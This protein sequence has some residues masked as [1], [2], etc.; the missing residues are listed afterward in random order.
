MNPDEKSKLIAKLHIEL[1]SIKKKIKELEELTRPISPSDAIG[2][3]SRMDAINN[4]SINESALRTAKTKLRNIE[5]TLEKSESEDFGKCRQCGT[6]IPLGRLMVM[7][8][9]TMCVGC[10]SR[11]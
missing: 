5:I 7:P 1:S 9:S 3:V 4:K 2:R 6:S 10:A 11:S 8:G